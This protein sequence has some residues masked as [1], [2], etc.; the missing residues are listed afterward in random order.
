MSSSSSPHHITNILN[1]EEP[2]I[3]HSLLVDEVKGQTTPTHDTE[4][5]YADPIDVLRSYYKT[6]QAQMVMGGAGRKVSEP[7]YQT[8]R[9]IQQ[10]GL[11]MEDPD[12]PTYSRPYD[13]LRGYWDP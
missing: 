6:Q 4:P 2:P 8:L 9:Q 10:A 7:P 13:C 5:G 12:D 1:L 11:S 3:P